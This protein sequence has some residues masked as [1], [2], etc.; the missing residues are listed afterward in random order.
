MGRDITVTFGDGTAHVYKNAPDNITPDAVK[1]R[2]TKEFGK[3]IKALDGGRGPSAP[4]ADDNYLDEAIQKSKP[5]GAI[6]TFLRGVVQGA[7]ANFGDEIVAGGKS[8]T[9]DG[10]Y[11]ANLA[12]ERQRTRADAQEHPIADITGNIVGAIAGPGRYLKKAKGAIDAIKQGGIMGAI[13]GFGQGEDGLKNRG[14]SAAAGTVLGLGTGAVTSGAAGLFNK[15][16]PGNISAN[17]V[18]KQFSGSPMAADSA[19][20]S[21]DLGQIYTPG[22]ATGSRSL[23][24]IEGLVRRHPASADT[25]QAFDEKQL[26]TS[27]NNLVTNLDRLHA[28]PSG[29]EATGNLVSKAFDNVLKKATTVRRATA[30]ADFGE[31]DKIAGNAKIIQPT[32]LAKA[33]DEIAADFSA[34]GGGDASATL[35]NQIKGIK[36]EL[37]AGGLTAKETGRLL[38]IYGK[39]ARGTGAVFKDMD[40][41]QQRLIA[42]RL[43][44]GLEADLDEA[45]DAGGAGAQV[46]DALR[47]ARGNYKTNSKAINELEKSVLGRMFG[48]EYDKAPERIAQT[49]R[50]MQPSELRQSLSILDKSDPSTSQV[51]KRYLVEDAMNTAGAISNSGAPRAQIGGQEMFSAPKFLTAIRKSNVWGSFSPEERKGMEQAVRDLERV[52]FRAGTDGSPTAPLLFAW[53]VAKAMGGG[54]MALSPT[55]IAKSVAAVMVPAKIAKAITTPQ[56][57]QALRTLRTAK[58]NTPAAA[59]ATSVLVKLFAP[60]GDQAEKQPAT[61]GAP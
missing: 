28:N 21:Q 15:V 4:S 58:P 56:G 3:P 18:N 9:G 36:R 34:P 6:P 51:V 26:S 16:R 53:E 45:A 49:I 39:A 10:T 11:D 48:A 1:A 41:G 57:Q 40:K 27:L 14:L 55:Q 13:Y 42:G 29:P 12:D 23:L 43:M 20:L 35:V 46:S 30:D 44:R 8:A 2:A 7:T 32:N 54:A 5:D 47:T 60:K 59:A 31:V 19:K 25:M 17:Y 33:I 37:D 61:G 24:T 50:N 38:E 22:Q 52:S